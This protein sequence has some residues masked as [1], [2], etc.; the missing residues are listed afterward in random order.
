M[1]AGKYL[2]VLVIT[3]IIFFSG[4]A[5]GEYIASRDIDR[6]TT[7]QDDLQNNIAALNLQADLLGSDICNIDV[8]D[9]TE[10][11]FELGRRLDVLETQLG[12]EDSAVLA[13]KNRYSLYSIQQY[14]LLERQKSLCSDY[15]E[16]ILFFY[17]NVNEFRASQTQGY[18]LDYVYKENKEDIAI[19]AFSLSVDN[20]AQATL[21]Q[22]H[23][24]GMYDAP[25][26]V[27]NGETYEG[28]LTS[29]EIYSVLAK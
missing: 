28:I 29:K 20:A 14:V 27:I 15:V 10:E 7:L 8:F 18:I 26:L 25:V 3:S 21:E 16:P 17:D 22:K 11:K 6:L 9:I 19:F 2:A 13:L 1:K 12:H 24:V 5:I 4:V 23:D